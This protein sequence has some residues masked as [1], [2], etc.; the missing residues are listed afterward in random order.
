MLTLNRNLGCDPFSKNYV[1]LKR[2]EITLSNDMYDLEIQ[3]LKSLFTKTA[4]NSHIL[5][6]DVGCGMWVR[7]TGTS[8]SSDSTLTINKN[9]GCDP[10]S[11]NYMSLNR[12]EITLL[13]DI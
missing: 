11:K 1:S 3:L 5:R 12:G 2:R 4:Q 6:L 8:A 10:F 13:N 9:V 7:R